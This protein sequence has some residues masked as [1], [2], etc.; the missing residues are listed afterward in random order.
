MFR[1]LIA[2]LFFFSYGEIVLGAQENITS[3]YQEALDYRDGKNQKVQDHQE[4]KIKFQRVADLS[5]DSDPQLYVKTLHN[6]GSIAY[7]AGIYSD[8]SCFFKKAASL[9]LDAS[10]RNLWRM[11]IDQHIPATPEIRFFALCDLKGYT[12]PA[13]RE[14]FLFNLKS[15]S[16]HNTGTIMGFSGI[17]TDEFFNSGTI[18]WVKDPKKFQN[19]GLIQS[20]LLVVG[21]KKID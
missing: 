16:V 12:I 14:K 7:N 11:I 8:A 6:L 15:P 20:L 21:D 2:G 1:S 5:K 17:Y 3:L 18:I 9:G 19:V 13:P 4:A 10:K